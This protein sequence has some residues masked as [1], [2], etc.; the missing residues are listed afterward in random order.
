MIKAISHRF[1]KF[2]FLFALSL[3]ALSPRFALA[4]TF[5][6]FDIYEGVV[7]LPEGL[8]ATGDEQITITARS[9]DFPSTV[10]EFFVIIQVGQ[11]SGPFAFLLNRDD[12]PVFWQLSVACQ[13][14]DETVSAQTHFPT[15]NIGDPLILDGVS[16][17][18][19]VG[20]DFRDL[21][22]SFLSVPPPP[23]P[24]EPAPAGALVPL[25]KLLL[26]SE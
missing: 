20:Q 4:Q 9:N 25:I 22:F 15:T 18:F 11:N 14:C 21:Q 6:M 12:A 24:L 16:F 2:S 1:L 7:S 17:N 10:V 8:V 26:D 5:D 3:M 19:A 23:P 13:N